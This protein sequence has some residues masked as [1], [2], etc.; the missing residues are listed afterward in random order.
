M[1]PERCAYWK[2]RYD[3]AWAEAE[4][5]YGAR[6]TVTAAEWEELKS[7]PSLPKPALFSGVIGGDWTR[8]QVFIEPDE[9]G[10]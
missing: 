2:A 6:L 7:D 8:V 10:A 5:P 4:Y 3:Q 1:T 9:V